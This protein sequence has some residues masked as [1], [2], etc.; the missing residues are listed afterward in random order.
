MSIANYSTP[1]TFHSYYARIIVSSFLV[2]G[3]IA[4]ITV[5]LPFISSNFVFVILCPLLLFLYCCFVVLFSLLFPVTIISNSVAAVTYFLLLFF[6]CC[7]FYYFSIVALLFPHLPLHD[8]YGRKIV[9]VGN[10]VSSTAAIVGH[11]GIA[12]VLMDQLGNGFH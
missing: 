6:F 2:V 1:E 11:S 12:T 9:G 5:I 10:E 4:K 8:Y 7:C 3:V